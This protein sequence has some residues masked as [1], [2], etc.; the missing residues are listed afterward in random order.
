MRHFL[1]YI[2]AFVF[3]PVQAQESAW[4]YLHDKPRA[5][6]Y[7]QHPSEMLSQRAIDRRNRYGIPLDIRDVPVDTHYLS[8]VRAVPGIT[9]K[10]K[11]KWMNTLYV[12][13]DSAHIASLLQFPFV[14]S[15]RFANRHIGTIAKPV[16]TNKFFA[17]EPPFSYG[18]DTVPYRLHNAYALHRQNYTG[19]GI[20]IAVIDA[21]FPTADTARVFSHIFDRQGVIDTYNFP[22]DTS[23][24][25]TRH[26]H[27]SVVWSRI[28]GLEPDKLIGTA[29]DADFCLY[30]SEDV[31]RE[32][33][34][35]ECWWVEAAERADSVGADVI[36]TSLGYTVFDRSDYNH[37]RADLDGKTA[38]ASRG[39]QIATE[40]GIHVIIAAGNEGNSGWQKISVPADARDVIAVGAVDDSGNRTAF[41][42]KG[43]TADGRIKPDVMSL[44]LHT[45]CYYA[46]HYY[47]LSGTSLA[48]PVITGFTADLVQAY[49]DIPPREMKQMILSASDRYEQPDSLYGYG[50][51]DFGKALQ[52][53][54]EEHATILDKTHIFPNPF[55][56]YIYL[57]GNIIPLNYRIYDLQ[58]KMMLHGHTFRMIKLPPLDP[59]IYILLL[60]NKKEA[61]TFK[62]I[63]E[64]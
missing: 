18:N 2:I 24:V 30:I 31:Y 53:L 7:L 23:F 42:S 44:G 8:N 26:Y 28:G 12:Q 36:N 61:K 16:Q 50:I 55:Y 56:N 46:G 41:S 63:K 35:E 29:P 5:D 27:G 13:G 49:P 59:G 4:V 58:G 14:D 37:T 17:L 1:V 51:P 38:F 6:Y 54:K 10:A 11:S 62:L 43:N 52:I 9:V 3:L 33:P 19:R 39:A 32:M 25:Y 60:Q 45:R 48:A 22:D 64:P 40:K 20:L 57:S 21:G 47:G 34:V 15:I